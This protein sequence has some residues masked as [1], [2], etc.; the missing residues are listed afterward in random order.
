MQIVPSSPDP[1]RPSRFLLRTG[2]DS[3]GNPRYWDAG[4]TPHLLVTGDDD[5]CGRTLGRVMLE[6]ASSGWK[7][8]TVD[9]GTDPVD[10]VLDEL[11]RSFRFRQ[12]ALAKSE[13]RYGYRT[14]FR[15]VVVLVDRFEHLIDAATRNGVHRSASSVDGEDDESLYEK[16]YRLI[17]A[18]GSLNLHLLAQVHP[19]DAKSEDLL[20][21]SRLFQLLNVDEPDDAGRLESER[22]HPSCRHDGEPGLPLFPPV[23]GDDDPLIPNLFDHP[24]LGDLSDDAP[25]TDST[26]SDEEAERF[27]QIL[28]QEDEDDKQHQLRVGID[29][30]HRTVYW[31][32]SIDP[33]LILRG[34]YE[35]STLSTIGL[36]AQAKGWMLTQ[37]NVTPTG[38]PDEDE[39]R[40]HSV[41]QSLDF[42]H[43][44]YDDA[45]PLPL[46]VIVEGLPELRNQTLN[47]RN[48][49]PRIR[50]SAKRIISLLRQLIE[51]SENDVHLL[52][53]SHCENDPRSFANLTITSAD[54]TGEYTSPTVGYHTTVATF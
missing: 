43:R 12:E 35:Q 36:D 2:L 53:A 29:P 20:D 28:E 9:G 42:I 32:A 41:E 10:H 33:H 19:A 17:H 7:L 45:T 51:E 14:V 49:L 39:Q 24:T 22:E 54:G 25:N 18:G 52:F 44:H 8:V 40:L 31:D 27:D 37:F 4:R 6:A 38:S 23:A 30:Q 3:R 48:S 13:D 50:L 5:A 16:L 46:L 11:M 15:P 47:T 26:V 21:D 1:S 34:D